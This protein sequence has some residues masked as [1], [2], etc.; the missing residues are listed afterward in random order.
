MVDVFCGRRK[1]AASLCSVGNL[2]FHITTYI[3]FHSVLSRLNTAELQGIR[4]FFVLSRRINTLIRNMLHGVFPEV[5]N[6]DLRRE[7]KAQTNAR[8]TYPR[9]LQWILISALKQRNNS[10]PT[11]SQFSVCF[12]NTWTKWLWITNRL[13]SLKVIKPCE[14]R[15]LKVVGNSCLFYI[16]TIAAIS[17]GSTKLSGSFLELNSDFFDR[18]SKPVE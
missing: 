14:C 16:K 7:G 12:E 10:V 1:T 13:N 5:W 4:T 8:P 2:E 3:T 6:G 11:G 17:M 18:P 9:R 15:V